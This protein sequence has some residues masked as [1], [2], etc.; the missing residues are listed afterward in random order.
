M[1]L[2]KVTQEKLEA[3]KRPNEGWYRAE[4]ISTEDK[5]SAPKEG[6]T[7]TLNCICE[8]RLKTRLEDGV[9]VFHLEKD[10][11]PPKYVNYEW[12]A[13]GDTP[14]FLCAALDIPSLDVLVGKDIDLKEALKGRE[15]NVHVKHDIYKKN[16]KDKGSE[17]WTIDGYLPASQ[18]PF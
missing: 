11:Y 14:Q 6:K 17:V 15:L 10:L 13:L 12:F 2:L 3:A 1:A 16:E 9:D 7:Q 18:V 8:V 5:M 4:I